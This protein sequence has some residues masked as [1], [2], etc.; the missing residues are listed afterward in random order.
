LLL[1]AAVSKGASTWLRVSSTMR[2]CEV[3]MAASQ[4]HERVAPVSPAITR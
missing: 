4:S 1:I 2:L 3:P